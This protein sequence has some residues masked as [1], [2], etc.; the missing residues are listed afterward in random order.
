MSSYEPPTTSVTLQPD[1]SSTGRIAKIGA[2][3]LAGLV[4]CGLVVD[5]GAALAIAIVA[6]VLAVL[7]ARDEVRALLAW[8]GPTL[9]IAGRG[10]ALGSTTRLVYNRRPRRVLDI[11]DC[12]LQ[13]R[14]YC[15]ERV[16]Y[17]RGTTTHTDSHTVF[18][19]HTQGSGHGTADGLLG[20][21]DLY[22]DPTAGG[23][24]LL[25]AHNEV[26]WFVEISVSGSHLPKDSHT[27]ELPVLPVLDPHLRPGLQD[28]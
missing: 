3:V 2:I 12:V 26:Q 24:T 25:L 11:A 22:I 14:L 28:S 7:F 17:T 6:V 19:R 21:V 18:E 20:E 16:T 4:V 9:D 13:C 23:P 5:P 27:F 1:S 15:R 10:L 8:H